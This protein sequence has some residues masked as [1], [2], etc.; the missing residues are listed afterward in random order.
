MVQIFEDL[1]SAALFENTNFNIYLSSRY[2]P[3]IRIPKYFIARVELENHSDIV[4]YIRNR[5]E[6]AHINE[7]DLALF[8]TLKS[9]IPNKAQGTFL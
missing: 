7:Q 8:D 3:Q 4:M 1:A 9:E 6:S 5:L 2:W